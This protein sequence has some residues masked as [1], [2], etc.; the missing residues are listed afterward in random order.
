MDVPTKTLIKSFADSNI[1]SINEYLSVVHNFAQQTVTFFQN[2]V[3]LWTP[4]VLLSRLQLVR[5]HFLVSLPKKQQV[6]VVQPSGHIRW[7]LKHQSPA[8]YS[9]YL[10]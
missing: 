7:S 4:W 9:I 1:H 2:L 5:N 3:C 8:D 6:D 10:N